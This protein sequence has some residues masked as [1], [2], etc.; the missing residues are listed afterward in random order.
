MTDTI[1][2]VAAY[3]CLALGVALLVARVA[4]ERLKQTAGI[5]RFRHTLRKLDGVPAEWTRAMGAMENL[6][7]EPARR[8]DG[9]VNRRH[10]HPS[11]PDER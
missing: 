5:W 2:E 4:G 1:L 10:R 8:N 9:Q 11:T 3:A 7:D 6:Q